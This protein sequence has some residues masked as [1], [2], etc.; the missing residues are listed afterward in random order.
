MAK[1]YKCD[2]CDKKFSDGDYNDRYTRSAKIKLRHAGEKYGTTLDI[3]PNCTD[4]FWRWMNK[5]E[6]K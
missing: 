4:S 6:N 5:K 2:R 3:C 1:M